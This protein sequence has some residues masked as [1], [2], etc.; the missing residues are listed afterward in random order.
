[1]CKVCVILDPLCFL[2]LAGFRYL[3]SYLSIYL[4]LLLNSRVMHVTLLK[5]VQKLSRHVRK[6]LCEDGSEVG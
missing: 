3:P 1:M 2:P 5:Q 6:R 4:P